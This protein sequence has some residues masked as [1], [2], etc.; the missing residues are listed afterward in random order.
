MGIIFTFRRIFTDDL[1]QK[2]WV[3]RSFLNLEVDVVDRKMFGREFQIY[4]VEIDDHYRM[5]IP[6]GW[7]LD[8]RDSKYLLDDLVNYLLC[9]NNYIKP[10]SL[11]PIK[12]YTLTTSIAFSKAYPRMIFFIYKYCKTTSPLHFPPPTQIL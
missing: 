10:P 3:L 4:G 12:Y 2:R 9:P 7:Y 5:L 11:L 8:G 6:C 1:F